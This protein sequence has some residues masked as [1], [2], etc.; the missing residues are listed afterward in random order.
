VRTRPRAKDIHQIGHCLLQQQ[1]ERK[2]CN[3]RSA[4]TSFDKTIFR[5]LGTE[6]IDCS[7]A[8]SGYLLDIA[9]NDQNLGLIITHRKEITSTSGR[10]AQSRRGVAAKRPA[11]FSAL[12]TNRFQF[13]RRKGWKI[14]LFERLALFL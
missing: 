14:L 6:R 2:K 10:S 5:E 12:T 7:P 9:A 4:A 8:G 1:Y 11:V 3:I 13:F